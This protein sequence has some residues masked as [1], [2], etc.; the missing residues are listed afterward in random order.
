[1]KLSSRPA[2]WL[3]AVVAMGLSSGVAAQSTWD[4]SSAACN[5]SGVPG[6]SSCTQTVGAPAVTATVT[7]WGNT[8]SGGK[9][10]RAN[11]TDQGTSGVGASSVA[12]APFVAPNGNTIAAGTVESTSNGHHAFDNV[13]ETD[14]LTPYLGGSTEMAMVQFSS[15]LSLT[16]V[17]VGW[18]QTDADISV[19]RWTGGSAGPDLTQTTNTGLTSSGWALVASIDADPVSSSNPISGAP[20][21]SW[22]LISTYFGG[23][24]GCDS[25][26]NNC[27]LNKG[28]DYFKLLSFSAVNGGGGGSGGVPE[29]TSLALAGV[30]LAGLIGARRRAAKRA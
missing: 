13:G 4:L 8:G 21:S 17:K 27:L 12:G 9:F 14:G 15:A 20:A 28:N 5:P 26:G 11:I 18:F 1:M 30:A 3:P 7:A 2:R 10:V 19:F 16:D 22:W 25:Y 23:N 6:S 24:S 29:P